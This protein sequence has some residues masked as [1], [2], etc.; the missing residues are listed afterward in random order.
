MKANKLDIKMILRMNLHA[1]IQ[2]SR[3]SFCWIQL[4]PEKI[5]LYFWIFSFN[6]YLPMSLFKSQL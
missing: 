2:Q 3:L 6:S 1:H 5:V 4:L